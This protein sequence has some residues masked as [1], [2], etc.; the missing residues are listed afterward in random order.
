MGEDIKDGLWE[1]IF[2]SHMNAVPFTET[3]NTR[4][5]GFEGKVTDLLWGKY[6]F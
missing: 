3:E 2:F 4:R 1:S 6:L 5:D